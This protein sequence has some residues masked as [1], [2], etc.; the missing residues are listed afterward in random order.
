[1]LKKGLI[2]CFDVYGYSLDDNTLLFVDE[3]MTNSALS[4]EAEKAEINFPLVDGN[5]NPRAGHAPL[6]QHLQ[7]KCAVPYAS[8]VA[9]V[10]AGN[11]DDGHP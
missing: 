3:N 8:V 5:G 11:S 4:S 2:K 6:G 7:C 9:A 10:V 1:M